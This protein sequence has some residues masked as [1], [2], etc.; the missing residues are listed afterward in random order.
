MLLALDQRQRALRIEARQAD[1]R[2]ADQRHGE[3][4]AN[5]HRVVERHDA[6]RA[7]AAAIEVLRDMGDRGGAL[8]AVPARHAL[9]RA[10]VPDV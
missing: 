1:E 8:G 4:R 9:G 10:V 7:L 2:A 6:E 5:A 3:Q